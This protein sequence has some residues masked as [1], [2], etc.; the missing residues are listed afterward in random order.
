MEDGKRIELLSIG[1]VAEDGRELYLENAEANIEQANDWVKENVIPHLHGCLFRRV[2]CDLDPCPVKSLRKI[3]WALIDFCDLE[4]HGKPEFWGYYSAYD[5][6]SLCR[7]FGKMIDLPKGW[8]MYTN[9]IKQWAFMLGDPTL[10]PER[11]DEHHALADARWN[12]K[13][14]EFLYL[15]QSG[16]NIP[17]A[18][19]IVDNKTRI[20][21]ELHRD[22][23]V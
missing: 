19:Y 17:N 5:H 15:L 8:P 12:K 10:P 11:K 9:D 2:K 6:V 16:F 21:P 14:W 23:K 22:L 7:I 18:P 1:L 20:F 4:K 13:A 3:K